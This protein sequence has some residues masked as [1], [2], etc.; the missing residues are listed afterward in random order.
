MDI[1]NRVI[2][3]TGGSRG[4]GKG[5]AEAFVLNGARVVIT[6]TDESELKTTAEEINAE[7]Y[8][9]DATSAGETENFAKEVLVKY[10][11]I[12][13]WLNNAGIQI[14]PSSVE[15]VSEENLK[16]LFSVNFFGY[17]Y[18]TQVAVRVMKKQNSGLIININSTAGLGGK[19]G[20]SA[21]VSSKFALKGLAESAREDLKD[22]KIN[23][24]QVFPGGIQTDIYHEKV[25]NDIDDYMSIDYVV[26]KIINNLKSINPE[27]DLVIKRPSV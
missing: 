1:N 14:A 8:V 19:P 20:L 18:G 21:Y 15:N 11:K 3:I 4:L 17:F 9:V 27:Q 2:V 13:V 6:S 24:Y 26:E 22:T 5:L 25:P 12:D 16:R 10:G 7:G 23:L